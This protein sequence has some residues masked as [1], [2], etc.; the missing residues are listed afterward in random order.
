[1]SMTINGTYAP[2]C[3]F[4]YKRPDLFSL[5]SEA[6]GKCRGAKHT[7][8]RVYIDGPKDQLEAEFVNK[9]I[10]AARGIDKTTF[11]SVAVFVSESNKGLAS[12]VISGVT[13]TVNMYGS[14]I[15]LEDDLIPVA[16]YLEYMNASLNHYQLM[17][18]VGSI[19]GF[20]FLVKSADRCAN[21]F[22]PRPNSWGWATWLDR[23]NM[24]IWDLSGQPELKDPEFKKKFNKGGQDLYRMLMNYQKGRIDSWAIRWAYSHYKHGWLASCPTYS[25]ISNM[26]YGEGGTNCSG[27]IPPP[28]CLDDGEKSSFLLSNEIAEKGEISRQVNWYNSN[29]YKILGRLRRISGI[30]FGEGPYA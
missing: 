7:D 20:G 3:V 26:G 16:N 12:S 1:M 9:T 11:R 5:C 15:V 25:K 6:L 4:A 8:L 19:S 23:W 29:V 21:Y 30:G 14:V 10:D 13:E 27:A 22:H 17:K 2:I 28:I 24:A 18:N